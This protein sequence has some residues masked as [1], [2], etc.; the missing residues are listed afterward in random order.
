MRKLIIFIILCCFVLFSCKDELIMEEDSQSFFHE[1]IDDLWSFKFDC[2]EFNENVLEISF[3]NNDD[4]NGFVIKSEVLARGEQ[5][6]IVL[7]DRKSDSEVRLTNNDLIE[8]SPVVNARGDF[9]YALSENSTSVSKLFINGNVIPET[10]NGLLYN[11]LTINDKYLA[12]SC[13]RFY[14]DVYFIGVFNISDRTLNFISTTFIP[15]KIKFIDNEK[16]ICQ[17]Y[18]TMNLSNDIFQL[19][20]NSNEIRPI[21]NTVNDEL[22]FDVNYRKDYKIVT[23]MSNTSLFNTIYSIN[24]YQPNNSLTLSNDFLGRLSWNVSY[25]LESMI[26]LNEKL[27]D[28]HLKD[29]IIKNIDNLLAV[30]NDNL[31]VVEDEYNPNF[32]WASKKYSIDKKTPICLMVNNARIL[33][34]LLLAY[35]KNI[36]RNKKVVELTGEMFNYFEKYFNQKD[37]LYRFQKGMNFWADGIMLPFNQQNAYGL[38]LI[39]MYKIT[40]NRKYKDRAS[41][42]L[43][44]FRSEFDYENKL[45]TWSYWP[46]VFYEGWSIE[47]KY[48]LNTPEFKASEDKYKEDINHAGLNVRFLYEYKSAFKD[49]LIDE[50]LN[51]LN[52]TISNFSYGNEFSRFIS[53]DINYTNASYR[54]MPKYGWSD[55]NNIDLL[56]FYS[57]LVPCIYPYFDN[58]LTYVYLHAITSNNGSYSSQIYNTEGVVIE[59]KILNY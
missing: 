13:S 42:L 8:F 41:S 26:L 48:S 51:D 49:L 1:N 47:D 50:D 6:E 19:N 12:F 37:S 53:G 23:P 58:E 34:P 3:S 15:Q 57:S 25:R 10:E 4:D 5:P 16:I 55:L 28:K 9:A 40:K 24:E 2:V 43:K 29:R 54:F 39:E 18:N 17:G 30:T 32:L 36:Y 46:K 35:N 44:K 27:R 7:I 20:I 33:Y 52:K 14:D 56:K 38:C 31:G 21:A 11:N 22:L 59:N 45:L